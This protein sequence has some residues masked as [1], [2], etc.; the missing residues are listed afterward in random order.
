ML[1]LRIYRV[2][3]GSL[4]VA[5]LL[6]GLVLIGTFFGYQRPGAVPMVPTGPIGHYFVAFTGCALL[7]WAGGLI[8]AARDPLASRTVGT[9]TVFV[10]ALMAMIR[11]V[12]WLIG[13][14]AVWLGD[15][16]RTEASLYLFIALA[17]VWTKPTVAESVRAESVVVKSGGEG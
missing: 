2:L 3:V 1:R 16:P 13:D 4:G 10:L 11:M 15:L 17:L 9:F 6:F 12:A 7:G 5:F 8:G 14:Y